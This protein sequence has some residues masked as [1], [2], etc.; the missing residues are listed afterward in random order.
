MRQPLPK[1][2]ETTVLL[3]EDRELHLEIERRFRG[4]LDPQSASET[5]REESTTIT[6]PESVVPLRE[7]L[8]ILRHYPA[9]SPLSQGTMI[10]M[11]CCG[12]RF[13]AEAISCSSDGPR[14]VYWPPRWTCPTCDRIFS[15]SSDGT[16]LIEVGGH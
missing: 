3:R 13:D 6:V 2:P 11:P 16:T 9:L 1:L 8:E 5:L 4:V 12:F 15:P 10:E 7:A 14:C